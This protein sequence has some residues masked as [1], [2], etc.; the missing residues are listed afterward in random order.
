MKCKYDGPN[1][2]CYVCGGE[3][4]PC[5]LKEDGLIYMHE[6]LAHGGEL[7]L[8]DRIHDHIGVGTCTM[9]QKKFAYE[10]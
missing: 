4:S 7:V 2:Y 8:I 10:M 6:N 1:K 9:S 5:I 3:V